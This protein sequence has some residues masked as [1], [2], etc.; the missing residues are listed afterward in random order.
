ME[1]IGRLTLVVFVA[2]GSLTAQRPPSRAEVVE[3]ELERNQ[4]KFAEIESRLQRLRELRLRHDMGLPVRAE[5]YFK[6]DEEQL[7]VVRDGVGHE[8]LITEEAEVQRLSSHATA[9][10]EQ[11]DAA[12][13]DLVA[14]A[15]A[16]AKDPEGVEPILPRPGPSSVHTPVIRIPKPTTTDHTSSHTTTSRPT[17]LLPVPDKPKPEEFHKVISGSSNRSAVGRILLRSGEELLLR[18]AKAEPEQAAALEARAKK[19]L[20]K[21]K[22]ELQPL[23]ESKKAALVDL[24]HLA[25]C[26]EKL[27]NLAAADSLYAQIISKDQTVGTD[28]KEVYG[29]WGRAAQAAKSVLRWIS[30]T[31]SWKP[32]TDIEKIRWETD[33]K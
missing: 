11:C 24:Y 31:G 30:D 4:R 29:K 25:R 23:Q 27:G 14:R 1:L 33:K 18:A 6:L 15:A 32:A 5:K 7:E 9:L 8:R 22:N 13:R 3:E 17:E 26:E 20:Q 19:L 12:R 10:A 16:Q 28:G 2:C 21:A